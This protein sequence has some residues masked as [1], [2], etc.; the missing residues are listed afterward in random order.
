MKFLSTPFF[1]TAVFQFYFFSN[2][3]SQVGIGT[4][5]PSSP[6]D[7]E[8]STTTTEIDINNTA[9]DGDPIINFQLNGTNKISLG[10]DDGDADKFKIGTTAIGTS[11]RLTIDTLGKVGINDD[12]P[13]YQLEVGSGAINITIG[14]ASTDFYMLNA[15]HALSQ[16]NTNNVYVGQGSGAQFNSGGTD[17]TFMGFNTG[18]ANTTADNC[19]FIGSNAGAVNTTG[20]QNT[21]VGH[22]AGTANTEG[23]ENLF[24]GDRA[25]A[26]N[27]NGNYNVFAGVNAGEANTA[28]YNTF[29]GKEA[30]QLNESGEDNTYIGYQA[31]QGNITGLE[32][33]FIGADCAENTTGSY[34]CV[35]GSAAANAATSAQYNSIFGYQAG[36]D[37]T[38]GDD[39]SFFGYYSGG[40]I[41]SGSGNVCIGNEA[42]P[43]TTS[44][45]SN[46]LYIDNNADDTP[47]I[48]GDFTNDRVGIGRVAATNS[49]E[50]SGNASKD[51]S[52]DWLANSDARLK[53][54]IIQ[55]NSE[56]IIKKMMRLQGV[57]Y[58]WNDTVTGSTRPTIKQYGFTA[59]NIQ[60]VFPLLVTEDNL[61]FLQT[62]Y[63]TYDAMYVECIKYLYD[64]IEDANKQIE[65]L[66]NKLTVLENLEAR[67]KNLE[68]N[69]EIVTGLAV[70]KN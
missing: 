55:M 5:N 10:V 23:Q 22:E 8:T 70:L 66:N 20:I 28:S 35:L 58:Y 6:L 45:A 14:D 67:I 34:N 62:P 36:L 12:N 3:F 38:T 9:V 25:G 4:S 40:N 29:I 21:F 2:S 51:A 27:L 16:P 64:K 47:L 49:L 52:G 7:I 60:E 57:T 53:R 15:Q 69:Q 43:T 54:D 30:G 56:E 65:L 1:L 46:L 24:I 63:G 31:G 17:N 48:Y 59:Q 39:N 44:T 42:G 13:A 26:S 50:V 11:T 68:N 61:G 19:T 32:N 18:N 33:T 41:T 37:L